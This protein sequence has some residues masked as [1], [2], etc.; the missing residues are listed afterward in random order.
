MVERFETSSGLQAHRGSIKYNFKKHTKMEKKFIYKPDL[1][2]VLEELADGA[3]NH[4]D[5]FFTRICFYNNWI[6]I[7]VQQ[8]EHPYKTLVTRSYQIV[9][10]LENATEMMD[11]LFGDSLKALES[12]TITKEEEH[13][14]KN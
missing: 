7:S 10:S 11:N 9:E 5:T 3:L 12:L 2:D 8:K 14:N 4:A 13:T 6:E 1:A